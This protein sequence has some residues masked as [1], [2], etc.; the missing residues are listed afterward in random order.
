MHVCVMPNVEGNLRKAWT[1]NKNNNFCGFFARAHIPYVIPK[2][3]GPW[4]PAGE[5][6]KTQGS[7]IKDIQR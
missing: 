3:K 7:D 4:R 6:K 1:T 2:E 5:Y